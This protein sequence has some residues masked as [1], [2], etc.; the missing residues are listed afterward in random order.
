MVDLPALVGP[1]RATVW[2]AGIESERPLRASEANGVPR[3]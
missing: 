3:I 2:F 1:T